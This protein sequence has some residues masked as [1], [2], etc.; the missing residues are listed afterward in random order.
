MRAAGDVKETKAPPLGMELMSLRGTGA[1]EGHHLR[2][3]VSLPGGSTLAQWRKPLLV[4][5][6]GIDD[7]LDGFYPWGVSARSEH[8]QPKHGANESAYDTAR[9]R[10][11]KNKMQHRARGDNRK[12]YSPKEMLKSFGLCFSFFRLGYSL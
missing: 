7:A 10:E 8:V 5:A 6:V 3:K 4:L 12:P 1:G 9:G 2:P 11:A